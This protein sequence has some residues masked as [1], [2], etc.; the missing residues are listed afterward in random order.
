MNSLHFIS[1]QHHEPPTGSGKRLVI[2]GFSCIIWFCCKLS[3]MSQQGSFR[4]QT[5]WMLNF[6]GFRKWA[7]CSDL[8][9]KHPHS[10]NR[11]PSQAAV[12]LLTVWRSWTCPL[13]SSSSPSLCISRSKKK[14]KWAFYYLYLSP[15]SHSS[16]KGKLT[17]SLIFTASSIYSIISLGLRSS[18]QF[19]LECGM[20]KLMYMKKH[21]QTICSSLKE[22]YNSIPC[23]NTLF[24]S[25]GSIYHTTWLGWAA[26]V[27]WKYKLCHQS[28]IVWQ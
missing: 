22:V 9:V 21:D 10:Q 13:C 24:L 6:R 7:D 28:F 17:H 27:F 25:P 14:D 1:H 15:V 4:P 12:P 11:N 5:I 18:C 23:P 20:Q 2:W 19:L 26:Y 8:Q 16:L 3:R